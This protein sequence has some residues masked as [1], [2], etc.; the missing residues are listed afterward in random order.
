LPHKQIEMRYQKKNGVKA[1]LF[2]F[3]GKVVGEVKGGKSHLSCHI[4]FTHKT[5]HRGVAWGRDFSDC[6]LLLYIFLGFPLASSFESEREQ[7]RGGDEESYA[8][9]LSLTALRLMP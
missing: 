5:Q 1:K 7:T 4:V 6:S 3:L 8:D 9:C 2:R